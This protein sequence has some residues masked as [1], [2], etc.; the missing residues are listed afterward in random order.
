MLKLSR[1]S[2][3][4]INCPVPRIFF[5]K[6]LINDQVHLRKNQSYCFIAG[7][8]SPK[9]GSDSPAIKQYD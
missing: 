6:S 2:K 4:S 7:P 1:Y 9:I 8:S 5:K 3:V